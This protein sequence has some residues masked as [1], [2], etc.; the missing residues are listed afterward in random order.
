MEEKA[1][2][3]KL[4]FIFDVGD[5]FNT[6]I[7]FVI[8][9]WLKETNSK[10][11]LPDLPYSQMTTFF[12]V[13][14]L[15]ECSLTEL[16]KKLNISKSSASQLV[17][18]LVKKNLLSRTRDIDNRRKVIINVQP[19]MKEFLS[20]LDEPIMD[21]ML[22]I[23]EKLGEKDFNEWYRIMRKISSILDEKSGE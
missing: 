21:W 7:D 13:Y 9:K 8:D 15:G 20:D 22:E 16:C 1:L 6:S 5:R 4:W 19:K 18:R 12:T 10:N 2:K 17:Q 23:A 3:D 14:R 11:L